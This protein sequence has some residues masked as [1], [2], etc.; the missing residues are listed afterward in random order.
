MSG[1]LC[2]DVRQEIDQSELRQTLS[3]SSEAHV[4]SCAACASFRD[5]RLRLRE[6]V[7]GL[8]PV[9]APADFE[10]RL[11]ARIAR[12]R[13]VP[14]QPFIFRFVMSTPAIVVAAV[15]VIAVGAIVFLSQKDRT[16]N[17]TA[18]SDT[19][20]EPVN[21]TPV[22][23]EMAKNH[24]PEPGPSNPAVSD[25][26]VKPKPFK[27]AVRNAAK[28]VLPVNAGPE[29]SDSTVRS[30]QSIRMTDR[31]GEVTLTAPLK[32]MI[33][34]VYDEHGGTHQ[35]QLPPISFGSQRLTNNRSQVSMTNMKN[36]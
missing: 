22:P 30:A 3:A 18:G 1:K 7:G 5:E 24:S 20:N 34:T 11:R 25:D 16:Q 10:M 31:N 32:P 36:W 8:Q 4:L 19:H 26:T 33:V 6:L 35:I 23:I 27:V 2:R 9:V 17:L 12:E 29:V 14:K 21:P 13:D 28:T 15:L